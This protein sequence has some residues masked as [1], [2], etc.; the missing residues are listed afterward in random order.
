M[1]SNSKK[2]LE[3][4]LEKL[5]GSQRDNWKQIINQNR[6]DFNK[7]KREIR[8]KQD[9]LTNLVKKKKALTITNE[10]FE[11]QTGKIQQELYELE[12]KILKLRLQSRK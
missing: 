3:K 5:E 9:D 8:K 1:E 6:D 2:K 10:E 7:I 11:Y 12:S 4:Y